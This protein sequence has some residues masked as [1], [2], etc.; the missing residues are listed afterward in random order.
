MVSGS[1]QVVGIV[2]S[3][4]DDA[5]CFFY[6]EKNGPVPRSLSGDYSSYPEQRKVRKN[7]EDSF[8]CT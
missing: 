1:G 2:D 8:Y 4:L 6:D 5:S 3:G 7:E